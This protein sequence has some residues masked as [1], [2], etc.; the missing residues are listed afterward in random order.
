[1][2]LAAAGVMV[3]LGNMM[4]W[5]FNGMRSDF[6][7]AVVYRTDC[8]TLWVIKVT[9]AVGAL[10]S[11]DD[12]EAFLDADC[13]IG[14]FRLAGIAA[15]AGFGVDLVDHGVSPMKLMGQ[16]AQAANATL[17]ARWV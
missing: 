6:G 2:N 10:A 12:V 7:D 16:I 14:A 3:T 4:V 9:F 8:H 17:S 5:T 1:M 11:A 15:R 13:R